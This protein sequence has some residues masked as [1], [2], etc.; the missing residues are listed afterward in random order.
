MSDKNSHFDEKSGVVFHE[1]SF[2]RWS[3]TVAEVVVEVDVEKG[4][5]GKDVVVVIKP[6]QLEC[7]VKGNVIFKVH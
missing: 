5:R 1:T 7:R 3:Q 2:G 6:S 4:T